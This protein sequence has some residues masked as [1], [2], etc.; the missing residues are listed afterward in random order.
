[1][2]AGLVGGSAKAARSEAT[3]PVARAAIA[4]VV[5]A[6]A[7]PGCPARTELPDSAQALVCP[8]LAGSVDLLQVS[9]SADPA[10]D[11]RIRAFLSAARGLYDVALDMQSLAAD[12]C[13]RMGHDLGQPAPPADASL[14]ALCEPVR[15][16][17]THLAASGV[18][19]RVSIAAPRCGADGERASRCTATC[20]HGAGAADCEPLCKAQAEL[21]GRC[22]MPSVA[23]AAS[24]GGEDVLR[25]VRTLE[26][27]LPSLL[28]AELALGRRL[29][30]HAEVI[31]AMSGRLPNDVKSAGERG[32]A[33]TAL[34][35]TLT[36]K[37]AAKLKSVVGTSAAT[38]AVLD[39][40]MHAP[41]EVPR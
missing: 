5:C 14:E 35:A 19:V 23:A 33:C 15:A 7:L 10:A 9:F 1:M 39:P 31:V 37:A 18:E 26:E 32:V 6:G 2:N 3:W 41:S 27:N 29:L 40:E 28:Y 20:G 21:Y 4:V 11:G 22:S 13:R 36:V 38:V 34:A 12:A 17:L 30:S 25:L 16:S 24:S 8:E